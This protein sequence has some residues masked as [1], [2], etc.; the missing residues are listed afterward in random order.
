MRNSILFAHG[1]RDLYRPLM[2]TIRQSNCEQGGRIFG[3]SLYSSKIPI[4][5]GIHRDLH[6]AIAPL[7]RKYR[8]WRCSNGSNWLSK[9][10]TP[11]CLA[12]FAELKLS[13]NLL[14]QY[15]AHS[16]GYLRRNKDIIFIKRR[17]ILYGNIHILINTSMI[18][19]YVRE[20]S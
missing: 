13:S 2:N 14:T 11:S 17:R 8:L 9:N 5:F 20:L 3:K 4:D 6:R 12:S 10:V 7:R 1:I 16:G 18:V 19:G 15:H